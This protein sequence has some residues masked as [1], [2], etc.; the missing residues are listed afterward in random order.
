MFN[1]RLCEIFN[2]Y[3][4][5]LLFQQGNHFKQTKKKSKFLKNIEPVRLSD[6]DCVMWNSSSSSKSFESF[7]SWDKR[8]SALQFS[9]SVEPT[10][11]K[12]VCVSVRPSKSYDTSSHRMILIFC[13]ELDIDKVRKLT[14]PD[15]SGKIWIIQ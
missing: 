13:M 3:G 9:T 7:W 5:F 6:E 15:S 14:R 1:V 4:D 2:G 11:E 12:I 10:A 8:D